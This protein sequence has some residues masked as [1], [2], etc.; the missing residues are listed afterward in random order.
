MKPFRKSNNRNIYCPL[1]KH[2]LY[3]TGIRYQEK[4]HKS[5]YF[6]EAYNLSSP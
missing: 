6:E 1:F 4:R 5:N 2:L 3:G